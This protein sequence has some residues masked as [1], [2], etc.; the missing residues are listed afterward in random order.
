MPSRTSL[1]FVAVT[2]ITALVPSPASASH[3]DSMFPSVNAFWSCGNGS[4]FCRTDNSTLTWFDE[5]TITY[6]GR[7]LINSVLETQF[8]PTDLSVSF[9]ST[10]SYSGA[11]E[12]D[13]IYRHADLPGDT[14]G[15]AIC[16]N[17]VSS[18]RCDQQYLTFDQAT[19]WSTVICHESGHGVGLLHGS[20]AS[21]LVSNGDDS[22]AC[23]QT[24]DSQVGSATLGSHNVAQINAAY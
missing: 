5:F 24:P 19:P 3:Y 23:L 15:T 4:N 21:P 7:Q 12:T 16:N 11:A 17:S 8:E 10:P 1:V 20:N 22:L 2:G 9:T 13:L 14:L 6:E 18:E